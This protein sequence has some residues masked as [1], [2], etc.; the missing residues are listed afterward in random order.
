MAAPDVGHVG[1]VERV[2]GFVGA[3]ADKSARGAADEFLENGFI[4]GPAEGGAAP[5]PYCIQGVLVGVAGP[6]YPRVARLQLEAM[7]AP[8]ARAAAEEIARGGPELG[9]IW[10]PT[11]LPA[12]CLIVFQYFSLLARAPDRAPRVCRVTRGRARQARYEESDDARAI[13]L[14]M[15][16][17][18][19]ATLRIALKLHEDGPPD[20]SYILD[21]L[22]RCLGAVRPQVARYFRK[23]LFHVEIDVFVLLLTA[24]SR[25]PWFDRETVRCMHDSI[26]A[27]HAES[28]HVEYYRE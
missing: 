19:M 20:T 1:R 5:C 7:A 22:L 10:G 6:M 27:T 14:T 28:E 8:I 15:I 26:R 17:L 23:M 24:R 18:F 25:A 9:A 21:R 3:S 12:L 16:M 4:D 11:V 13:G 2:E